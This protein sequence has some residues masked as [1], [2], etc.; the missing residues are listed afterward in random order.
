VR[1]PLVA[2]LDDWAVC[3]P[4]ERRQSWLLEVARRADPDPWRDRVRNPA[5][6][7]DVAALAELARTADV[8]KQP[9]HLLMSLGER[10]QAT[11]GEATEFLRRVQLEH[12]A[13][14]WANFML[15]TA[16]GKR[17]PSV[18]AGYY[19]AAVAIR[20][21]A[22]AVQYNLGVALVVGRRNEAI[23]HYRWVL[24]ID[25]Q[26]AWAHTWLGKALEAEGRRDEALRHYQ[27]AIDHYEHVLRTDRENVLA[28]LNLGIG[29]Q[30]HGRLDEALEHFRQAI[31]LDPNNRFAQTG[32]RTVLLR[33]GRGEE[34]RLAF[35]KVVETNSTEH[36]D[37]YGYAELCLYL[38]QEDEYRRARTA[39]LAR[40]AA[41][42][43]PI[44][45]ERTG[46]ACLIL[47]ASGDE[48]RQAFALIDRAV[49]AERSKYDWPYPFFLFAKG[50]ADY[51]QKRWDDAITVMNGEAASVMGPCPGLVKAMAL[52]QKGEKAQARKSLAA[53]ILAFDWSPAQADNSGAW[54]RHVL[55][56]EAEALI[57]ADL[58]AFLEGKYQPRDNDNR[59]ALLGVCQYQDRRAAMAGLYAAAFAADPKL[60]EDLRAGHRF[61]AARAAAVAGCGGGADGARLGEVARTRWRQ[62]ACAWLRLDLAAWAQR[63]DATPPADRAAAQKAL[64]RWR[65]DPDL[66]GLRDPAVL[67]R[68]PP[69]EL[70]ECRA[71]WGDLDA[72]IRRAQAME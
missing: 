65:Q 72:L 71:L 61:N 12:P 46:R 55:R 1:E 39:L 5:A 34:A 47:P 19:R 54:I 49:A 17:L 6:W 48:L 7:G 23:D 30:A 2:A 25:P 38:G 15:A 57:L 62:Q 41:S 52:Q 3:A 42:T 35:Q 43:D 28:H 56:R 9:V 36:E 33:Q 20:P 13:D 10:L 4:Q 60:A 58:P 21:R 67:D 50:L 32:V 18:A 11:G 63:L 53:A 68:L 27:Q 16:L 8:E 37:W 44:V 51:R 31:A 40:F 14:F 24:R 45:A 70:Q 69:A 22:V 64:A 29:L 66:T 26:H 59:L